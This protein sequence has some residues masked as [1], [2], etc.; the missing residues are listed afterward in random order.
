[1]AHAR[2]YGPTASPEAI[3]RVMIPFASQLHTLRTNEDFRRCVNYIRGEG[4]YSKPVNAEENE[5][6]RLALLALSAPENQQTNAKLDK[7]EARA[8]RTGIWRLVMNRNR[9]PEDLSLLGGISR[10]STPQDERLF[11][12]LGDDVFQHLLALGDA[13]EAIAVGRLWLSSLGR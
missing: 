12:L 10:A 3:R 8:I 6:F 13:P 11:C 2:R 5:N 9:L 7:E 4:G 1:M